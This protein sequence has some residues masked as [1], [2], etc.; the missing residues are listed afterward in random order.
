MLII[1][2]AGIKFNLPHENKTVGML[3]NWSLNKRGTNSLIM[4]WMKWH[5][6]SVSGVQLNVQ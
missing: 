6:F 5:L 3:L 2:H 1:I 4:F